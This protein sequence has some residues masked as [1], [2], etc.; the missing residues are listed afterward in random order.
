MLWKGNV[1]EGL[2]RGQVIPVRGKFLS[3]GTLVSIQPINA[4]LITKYIHL[5]GGVMCRDVLEIATPCYRVASRGRW[6][7]WGKAAAGEMTPPNV[8]WV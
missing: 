7:G 4:K 8:G 1:V 5:R 2:Y 3:V 6:Q